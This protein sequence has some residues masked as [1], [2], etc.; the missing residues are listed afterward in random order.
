MM[1]CKHIQFYL[2]NIASIFT[3]DMDDFV[4]FNVFYNLWLRLV[5]YLLFE[6]CWTAN[7]CLLKRFFIIFFN[8]WYSTKYNAVYISAQTSFFSLFYPFICC[9]KL[10]AIINLIASSKSKV[11]VVCKF[12]WEMS[13]GWIFW[14]EFP[15]VEQMEE[16]Y[17]SGNPKLIN[18]HRKPAVIHGIHGIRQPVGGIFITIIGNKRRL[19]DRYCYKWRGL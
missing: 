2:K 15:T 5:G 9:R 14:L 6:F 1:A 18:R 12:G 13:K 11:N 7:F 16:S 10:F 4:F 8:V 3:I 17:I 19:G